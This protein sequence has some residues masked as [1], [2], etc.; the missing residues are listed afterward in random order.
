[1]KNIILL[2]TLFSNTLLA[3][4]MT[5][6]KKVS[7]DHDRSSSIVTLT[8]DGRVDEKNTKIEAHST[9]LDITLKGV[10]V[11]KSGSFVD[12]KGPYLTKA[13]MI[14]SDAN[15]SSLRVFVTESA[16]EIRKAVALDNLND[17]ILL[18]VDYGILAK[19]GFVRHLPKTTDT[20][21]KDGLDRKVADSYATK[22]EPSSGPSNPITDRRLTIATVFSIAML[23]LMGVVYFFKLKIRGRRLTSGGSKSIMRTLGTYALAP[24]QNLQLI[25]IGSEKILLGVTP[26]NISFLTKIGR[27]S[28]SLQ[29]T[30]YK[31]ERTQESSTLLPSPKRPV[32]KK[33]QQKASVR[34]KAPRKNAKGKV[35][36]PMA[37]ATSDIATYDRQGLPKATN[38]DPSPTIDDVTNLIRRKLKDLPSIRE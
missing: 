19:N 7:G 9:F 13:V 36:E 28:G 34:K 27:E 22:V 35:T 25:E 18:T 14:Q 30:E 26:D 12:L 3:S 29:G 24:K 6:L 23:S 21:A 32:S 5:T 8:F 2:A 16:D 17:R 11:A 38:K 10:M 1:M 15:T 33:L 31:S 20:K 37:K 4:S